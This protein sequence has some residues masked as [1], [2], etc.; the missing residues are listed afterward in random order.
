MYSLEELQSMTVAQ[1]KKHAVEQGVELAAGLLKADIVSKLYHAQPVGAEQMTIK[2]PVRTAMII[3]DD[4]DDIPVMTVNAAKAPE[5]VKAVV[6]PKAPPVKPKSN[7]PAFNLA[8]AKAWHNPQP[9]TQ[10]NVPQNK[11]APQTQ[12]QP[13]NMAISAKAGLTDAKPVQRQ[14]GF[15]RFGPASMQEPEESKEA[16]QRRLYYEAVEK[17][18]K[19]HGGEV[20]NN[21]EEKKAEAR[22]FAEETADA[23]VAQVL[24]SF[25]QGSQ[26]AAG[27]ASGARQKDVYTVSAQEQLQ[28][29]ELTERQG[30]LEIMPE[31]FGT[32]RVHQMLKSEEDIYIS[33]AQVRRYGLRTGDVVKGQVRPRRE[34]DKYGAMI[35]VESVN[36]KE[37]E[38]MPRRPM[39]E[40][41]TAV[42]PGKKIKLADRAHPHHTL[43]MM[44]LFA[45]IAFGQRA[46]IV[47]PKAADLKALRVA[48]LT[49]MADNY[50]DVELVSLRLMASP[51][52]MARRAQDSRA[53]VVYTT[54]DMALQVPVDVVDLLTERVKRAVESGRDI[55]LLVEDVAALAQAYQASHPG[56]NLDA[57]SVQTLHQVLR[58]LG[59]GRQTKEGGSVTVIGLIQEEDTALQRALLPRAGAVVSALARLTMEKDRLDVDINASFTLK[60]EDIL[61]RD[62]LSMV[63]KLREMLRG[64]D[65]QAWM[66]TLVP[67]LEKTAT[68]RELTGRFEAWLA[69]MRG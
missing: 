24:N 42:N 23:Q 56:E 25:H 28:A 1:L 2:P 17:A 66:E 67:M 63:E 53:E 55:V 36:G 43:R 11:Y 33:N 37:A 40:Q 32:L 54:P 45:P 18:L 58:V 34:M 51:E 8:G 27:F 6:A 10:Q 44:S 57:P 41:M 20:I 60:E 3:A 22:P 61:T 14:V 35:Y 64:R 4:S 16:V 49:A 38:D 26:A 52:N 39:F 59:L 46:L 47:A 65:Q 5:T 15:T 30:V 69:M 48:M 50:P 7:K 31:G 19:A 21:R 68:N 9:F 62:E 12:T 13:I 29:G